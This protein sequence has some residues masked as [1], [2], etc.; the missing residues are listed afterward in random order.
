MDLWRPIGFADVELGSNFF[1]AWSTSEAPSS[2]IFFPSAWLASWGE[3][4]VSQNVLRSF[5]NTN[6]TD[7]PDRI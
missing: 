6:I 5:G 4:A 7:K 1:S 2:P 3:I